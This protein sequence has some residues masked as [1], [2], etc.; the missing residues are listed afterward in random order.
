MRSEID[1]LRRDLQMAKTGLADCT[2][3]L[4]ASQERE[5]KLREENRDLKSKM[6]RAVEYLLP[7][8]TTL[9][10]SWDNYEEPGY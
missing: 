7:E 1:K 10:D 4:A 3:A 2:K 9:S 5:H 8:D 6:R